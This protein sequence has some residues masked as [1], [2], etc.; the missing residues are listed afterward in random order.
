M[1]ASMIA[2]FRHRNLPK[3]LQDVNHLLRGENNPSRNR[4]RE[5]KEQV[6]VIH[7]L[8]ERDLATRIRLPRDPGVPYE[9]LILWNI[10]K[11]V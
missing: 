2:L 8:L 1:I 5:S 9:W 11:W 7:L 3:L 6:K 10:G 4:T